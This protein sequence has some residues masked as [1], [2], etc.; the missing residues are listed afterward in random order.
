MG[1]QEMRKSQM[2]GLPGVQRSGHKEGPGKRIRHKKITDKK[3]G[4]QE[5]VNE[6]VISGVREA[7]GC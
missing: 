6:K 2:H 1:I 7:G 5:V 3:P 4:Q